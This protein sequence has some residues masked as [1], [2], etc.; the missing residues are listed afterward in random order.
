MFHVYTS[1]KVC[2]SSADA[3]IA[4]ALCLLVVSGLVVVAL[5]VYTGFICPKRRLMLPVLVSRTL[6]TQVYVS[7]RTR[8]FVN[9]IV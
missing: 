3:M 7:M 6:Q 8:C 1:I 9:Q 2:P 5:L 4:A